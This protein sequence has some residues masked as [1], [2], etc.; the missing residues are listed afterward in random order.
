MP[1]ELTRYSPSLKAVKK[2]QVMA[3]FKRADL[4]N[5]GLTDEQIEF[6]M[7][8]SGRALGDYELKSNVQT[9]IDEALKNVT[10]AEVN[11]LESAEYKTL[12][13]ENEKLK[14]LSTD[15][16]SVVK[17]PYKDI[18]W[19]KLD[20]SEEHKPYAE[21]LNTLSE[22]LPDLFVSQENPKTPQ[23]AG[24]TTG[25]MPKGDEAPSFSNLWGFAK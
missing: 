13:A 18:V 24:G 4:K 14:A 3:L 22:Q 2:G 6:I 19:G 8:E 1:A 9:K 7:T 20:H 5:K 17:A 23:F 12:F 21:Q 25:T 10:P 16:F 11:V 15:D